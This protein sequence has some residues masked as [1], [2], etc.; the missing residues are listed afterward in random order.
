MVQPV[1]A[2]ALRVWRRLNAMYN[3]LGAA[4]DIGYDRTIDRTFQPTIDALWVDSEIRGFD[5][6][7]ALEGTI[8]EFVEAMRVP[9]GRCYEIFF[10]RRA[11]PTGTAHPFIISSDGTQQTE[12]APA[13]STADYFLDRVF[14]PPGWRI[15]SNGTGNAGDTA[16]TF[17]VLVIDHPSPQYVATIES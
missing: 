12:L 4:L 14:V 13:S 17:E 9:E 10:M 5:G 15:G 8:N 1:V 2:E 3:G 6:A 16:I 11:A 7:L